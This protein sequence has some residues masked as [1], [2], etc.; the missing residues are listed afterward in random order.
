MVLDIAL[1]I[2]AI[3]LLGTVRM[4]PSRRPASGVGCA[5]IRLPAEQSPRLAAVRAP[6]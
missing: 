6:R 1:W 3:G 2:L 5:L 4:H